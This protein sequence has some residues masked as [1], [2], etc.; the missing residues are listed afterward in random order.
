MSYDIF[1]SKFQ[2]IGVIV[3]QSMFDRHEKEMLLLDIVSVWK[4]L[5]TAL[6]EILAVVHIVIKDLA[7]FLIRFVFY[8]YL[9]MLKQRFARAEIVFESLMSEFNQSYSCDINLCLN[10]SIFKV[11]LRSEDNL[12]NSE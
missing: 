7:F 6:R 4:K 3:P 9:W 1:A 8:I 12:I 11:Y 10:F 2:G 5:V